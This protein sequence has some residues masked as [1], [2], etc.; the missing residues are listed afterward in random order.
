MEIILASASPRRKVLLMEIIKD[1]K[2][3]PSQ[4]DEDIPLG[5][6]PI[7]TA[8]HNALEKAQDISIS[9]PD[10]I[11]IGADTV[12][13]LG[14]VIMGKPVDLQDAVRI[15][16][17]LSGKTHQVITGVAM[18]CASK[19]EAIVEFDFSDVTFRELARKQIEAY[20]HE[21]QPLD[22]A[23]SYGIQEVG[24][25]FVKCLEGSFE[26]VMGLPVDLVAN[27]LDEM[28]NRI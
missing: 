27:M 6:S 21:K 28:L 16:A 17:A 1:F 14:D 23:G 12:V 18:V 2:I 26:N 19:N 13:A 15:L 10:A 8:M 25:E 3:V 5:Q 22:K 4:I 24:E 7:D 11:V 20:V 9:H